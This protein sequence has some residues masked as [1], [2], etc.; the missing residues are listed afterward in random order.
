MNQ[1]RSNCRLLA[2]VTA[3]VAAV[4]AV[5]AGAVAGVVSMTRVVGLAALAMVTMTAIILAELAMAV[6]F[7][8]PLA[9]AMSAT[10]IV[11]AVVEP[12]AFAT[13]VNRF[14]IFR[15]DGHRHFGFRFVGRFN[16]RLFHDFGFDFHRGLCVDDHITAGRSAAV[17]VTATKPAAFAAV[18]GFTAAM[19]KAAAGAAAMSAMPGRMMSLVAVA[20]VQGRTVSRQG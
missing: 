2:L 1:I 15:Q 18:F 14:A 4:A 19:G 17:V 20:V 3:V 10:A 13:D 12:A 5:M 9:V 8:M 7:V 16:D 11:A 6:A